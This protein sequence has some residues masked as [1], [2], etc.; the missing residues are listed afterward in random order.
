MEVTLG[1]QGLSKSWQAEFP[2]ETECCWCK[3]MARIGF[4]ASEEIDPKEPA[5]CAL[6]KNEGKG[7]Y[8]LHD[9]ASFAIYL[10][11]DCLEATTLYNQAYN[12]KPLLHL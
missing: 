6:H 8:W 10:C 7:G 5:V 2:E 1:K 12:A 11:K 3:G 9:L 4:V